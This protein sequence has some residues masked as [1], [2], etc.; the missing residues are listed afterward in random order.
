MKCSAASTGWLYLGTS[1]VTISG[2]EPLLHPEIEKIISRI[3]HHG[4]I[5]GIITN[6]YLL[7]PKKIMALNEA[8]LE[9]LQI[10]I[11][12]VT[13]D[14]VSMKSLK[15]LDKKLEY[16]GRVRRVFRKHQFRDRRRHPEPGGRGS[17]HQS[18]R[19][20]RLFQFAWNHSRRTAARSKPLNRREERV[21]RE[22]KNSGKHSYSRLNWFQENLARGKT[23][24]LALPRRRALPLYLRR[25]PGPLLLAAARLSRNSARE[26]HVR[27]HAARILREKGHARPPAPSVV[28]R[29]FLLLITGAIRNL[30]SPPRSGAQPFCQR[31]ASASEKK[32]RI[33]RFEPRHD[34]RRQSEAFTRPE[35]DSRHRR[36]SLPRKFHAKAD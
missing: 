2:G 32:I 7:T 22:I 9:H 17:H 21:Y 6:G 3:R 23:E 10:S 29:R 36:R 18:R 11:D 33:S 1:I 16:S 19:R 20:A 25:R 4:M 15:V 5:A 30:N 8:G 27:R 34:S 28:F 26:I 14:D 12:N 13:P 31:S 24:R 35:C